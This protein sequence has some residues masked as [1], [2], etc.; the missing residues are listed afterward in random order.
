MSEP[1]RVVG[2][3]FPRGGRSG[4]YRVSG[5]APPVGSWV[6]VESGRGRRLGRVHLPLHETTTGGRI[7]KVV[8]EATDEELAAQREGEAREPEAH[9]M[10]LALA[11]ARRLPLRVVQI[12]LDA[13][14]GKATLAA[15]VPD[16]LD[17]RDYIAELEDAVGMRVHVRQ[18][19]QRDEARQVEGVGR[20]GEELCCSRFLPDYPQTSIRMAK[21]QGLSLADDRTIGQC[22]RTLCCLAYEQEFY[23]AR[24]AFLPRLGKRAR[25]ADGALE[26]KAIGAD[27]LRMTFT[28]LTDDGGRHDVPATAWDRNADRDVPPPEIGPVADEAPD[29]V[30]P[31]PKPRFEPVSA[32]EP[33]PPRPSGGD[34]R[35]PRRKN[36]RRR[37]TR[38]PDR[39]EDS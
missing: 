38:G 29:S 2:V 26:G 6:V 36:R 3:T 31:S 19:G 35:P 11:R 5:D 39:S 34:A 15:V 10:A 14:A 20:C 21:D 33:P 37:R 32:D 1:R 8:R 22:G 23:K 28:L 18:L 17:L 27:V 24:R 25:T 4:R 7:R 13:F 30:D 9:R 12:E 16:T